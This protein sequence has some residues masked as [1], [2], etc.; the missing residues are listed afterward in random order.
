MVHSVRQTGGPNCQN[1]LAFCCRGPAAI[2]QVPLSNSSLE[3]HHVGNW[4]GA[5]LLGTTGTLLKPAYS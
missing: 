4:N 5:Q 2:M 1:C 3:P